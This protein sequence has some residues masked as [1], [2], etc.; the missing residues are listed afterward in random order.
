MAAPHLAGGVALLWQAKPELIGDIDTTEAVF[1]QSSHHLLPLHNC[2]IGF[3]PN[4]VYGWG[5]LDLLNAVQ[6]R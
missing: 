1:T 4:N 5:L 2:G 3:L 6:S